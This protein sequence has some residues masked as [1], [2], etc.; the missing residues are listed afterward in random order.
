MLRLNE[1]SWGPEEFNAIRSCVDSDSFTMGEAVAEF[2][3]NFAEWLGSKFAIMVNSGSSANLLAASVL[4][5]LSGS[6]KS[7]GTVIVP[8]LSWSTTYYPWI[9][10]GYRLSFVD[11]N[12]ENFNLDLT[13]L[14]GKITKDVVG[15][16]VPH[17]L[18]ADAGIQQI[19]SLAK[20]YKIWVVEDTCESLGAI[21][22][23]ASRKK[24]LGTFGD[25]GTFSFF[26]S[27][28]IS[29]M[30]GGMLVTDDFEKYAVAKSMRAHGWGRDVPYSKILKNTNHNG[31]KDR[32]TF[33]VPGYNLRPLEM[34]GA[35]GNYQLKRLDSFVAHRKVNA[36]YFKKKME[37]IPQIVLQDQGEGGSWMAFAFLIKDNDSKKRDELVELLENN[38]VE[39]RPIVAGNFL[40]QPVMTHLSTKSILDSSY[41]VA[42]KLDSTGIMIA[43]H[44][45]D[46]TT[47]LDFVLNLIVSYF[48][49]N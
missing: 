28:H 26:R 16:C 22:T 33:Y 13:I 11:I 48:E 35:I 19:M 8:A 43:N 6:D 47:E 41:P 25:F 5:F 46:L 45:R 10:N 40:K 4:S 21:A 38:G 24:K 39:T 9:Q 17:I 14:E 15:I 12:E 42:D 3:L 20:K 2:E 1:S 32:F 27:H 36:V 18:G 44:G 29:T 37:N 31:W 49:K 23:K 7:M 30:E 34:S